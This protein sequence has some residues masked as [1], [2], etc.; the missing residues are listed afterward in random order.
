MRTVGDDSSTR[1]T[2][3]VRVETLVNHDPGVHGDRSERDDEEMPGGM[4]G[5]TGRSEREHRQLAM[6]GT[7]DRARSFPVAAVSAF[8]RLISVSMREAGNGRENR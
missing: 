4:S 8:Q 5:G 1:A 2:P 6:R 7:L 3:P